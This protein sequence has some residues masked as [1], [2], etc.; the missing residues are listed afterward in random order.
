MNM[1]MTL[2]DLVSACLKEM[3]KGN[4]SKVIMVGTPNGNYYPIFRL[5]NDNTDVVQSKVET[6]FADKLI[7]LG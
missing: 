3:D 5:F 1:P 4:S 6:K 2:Q 7:L